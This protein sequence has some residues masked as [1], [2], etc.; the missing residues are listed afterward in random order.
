MKLEIQKMIHPHHHHKTS[1]FISRFLQ[2]IKKFF[3][4]PLPRFFFL[5][6]LPIT[7]V[8]IFISIIFY[9]VNENWTLTEATFYSVNV[10]LGVGFGYPSLKSTHS[11]WFSIIHTAIGS[12]CVNVILMFG[13]TFCLTP[14]S[15]STSSK[16]PDSPS[17]FSY[18]RFHCYK[19]RRRI[20]I[21][22]VC[23]I[24]VAIGTMFAM[25][26]GN[27][28]TENSS[29][30][31]GFTNGVLFAV[32][33]LSSVAQYAPKQKD[34]QMIFTCVYILFGTP[35]WACTMGMLGGIIFLHYQRVHRRAEARRKLESLSPEALRAMR[36][37]RGERNG[38]GIVDRNL[39]I[40]YGTFLEYELR[41]L[42]LVDHKM[43]NILRE[44]FLSSSK[45]M[46]ENLETSN[47]KKIFDV[48]KKKKKFDDNDDDEEHS[49]SD[50]DEDDEG[51][52]DSIPLLRR[53]KGS[54]DQD[55]E[56]AYLDDKNELDTLLPAYFEEEEDEDER[57]LSAE[58]PSLSS[59]EIGDEDDEDND[60]LRFRSSAVQRL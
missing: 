27:I 45:I 38:V 41:Q 7:I 47:R 40:D 2:R 28:I 16:I 36:K 53:S 57:I 31:G 32:S 42:R 19:N 12:M 15:S 52:I 46:L 22:V 14:S 24:Y 26:P 50:Y 48:S 58:L 34:S 9:S 3:S 20:L 21:C 51:L 60:Y 1:S 37:M 10:F 11:K 43:L 23:I 59:R 55:D 4:K 49:F 6:G 5:I 17:L 29:S 33:C 44:K 56:F 54:L 25:R 39:L 35:L 18:L 8:W 30:K 13:F